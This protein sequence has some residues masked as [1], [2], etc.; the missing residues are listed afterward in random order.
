MFICPICKET[1]KNF[2]AITVHIGSTH[3]LSAKEVLFNFYPELFRNCKNCGIKIKS[4]ISNSQDIKNC[5]KNCD[6]QY[7]KKPQSQE[8]IQKRV[9]KINYKKMT[10]VRSQNNLLKY[11]V[12]NTSSLPIIK[13][14]ISKSNTGIKRPRSKE[15]QQKII[16]SKIKNGT[17]THTQI[18]KDKI[19]NILNL[20]YKNTP[21]TEW[22][23]TLA[24]KGKGGKNYKTGFYK[25]I[26]FRSSYEEKF[27]KFCD[28]LQ[29][30][31][32]SAGI[33]KFRI[34]YQTN[35]NKKHL[36][37]PDFYLPNYN[38]IIEIKPLSLLNSEIN[39]IKIDTACTKIENFLLLTEEELINKET[40]KKLL[41]CFL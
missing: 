21:S 1:K 13:E 35:D 23:V 28:E 38:I 19:S 31:V 40:L 24:K 15:W 2:K 7:R 39:Q 12:T 26:W 34:E 4:W 6:L 5:S 10:E 17:I 29:I 14:K 18:T 22:P 36:Y 33:K 11:G 20:K 37:Y 27:L 9:S 8:T 3:H 25:K 41:D 32:E 16:N 30:P